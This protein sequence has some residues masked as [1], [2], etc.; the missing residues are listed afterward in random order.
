M[1]RGRFA[2]CIDYPRNVPDL[3]WKLEHSQIYYS[4]SREPTT[5]SCNVNDTPIMFQLPKQRKNVEAL[6]K[7]AFSS[8]LQVSL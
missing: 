6:M 8:D 2:K 1:E 3:P 4:G 7:V 5:H